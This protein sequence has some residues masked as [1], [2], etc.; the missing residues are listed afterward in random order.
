MH[1]HTLYVCVCVPAGWDLSTRLARPH[2][3]F[4]RFLPRLVRRAL[5]P[6]SPFW[7][8]RTI[9]L[10]LGLYCDGRAPLYGKVYPRKTC[11]L[12]KEVRKSHNTSAAPFLQ[13]HLSQSTSS[14]KR[15]QN[16]NNGFTNKH[17]DIRWS[18]RHQPSDLF[19][20]AEHKKEKSEQKS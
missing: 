14:T 1:I 20:L 12:T 3:N 10:G 6:T 2:K 8:A 18:M 11:E 13:V 9:L 15:H 4:P 19:Y 7:P 5:A 17:H 16:V